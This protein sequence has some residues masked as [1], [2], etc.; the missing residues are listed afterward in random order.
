MGIIEFTKY[1]KNI[2]YFMFL[3]IVISYINVFILY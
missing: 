1:L 2:I 3:L